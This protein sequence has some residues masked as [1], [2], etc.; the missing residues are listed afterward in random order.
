MGL[1]LSSSA[2]ATAPGN[3]G[4]LRSAQRLGTLASPRRPRLGQNQSRRTNRPF[5]G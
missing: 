2:D 1:A 5:V 4:R 3:C